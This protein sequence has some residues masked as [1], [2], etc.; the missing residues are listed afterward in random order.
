MLVQKVRGG[1]QIQGTPVIS[2]FLEGSLLAGIGDGS[3]I[4]HPVPDVSA[5][6]Y[7]MFG[8]KGSAEYKILPVGRRISG[9]IL[10]AVAG[11]CSLRKD[12]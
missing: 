9:K 10:Y 6:A 7:V 12:L 1:I 2:G 11:E 5:H 3:A 8:G 4:R